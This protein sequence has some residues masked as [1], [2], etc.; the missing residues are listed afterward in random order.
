MDLETQPQQRYFAIYTLIC[1]WKQ[2]FLLLNWYKIVTYIIILTFFLENCQFNQKLTL[3]WRHMSLYCKTTLSLTIWPNLRQ[4][5]K[6]LNFQTFQWIGENLEMQSRLFKNP[7]F[8][9]LLW[10]GKNLEIYTAPDQHFKIQMLNL[11]M[12]WEN[13]CP[14]LTFTVENK[15][16]NSHK[17]G[18][19][20]FKLNI[21]KWLRYLIP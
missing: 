19:S 6:N 3:L 18:W 14:N 11:W 12:S 10:I 4:G 15:M 16:G 1:V 8:P 9:S 13:L 5:D 20:H 17:R 21:Y 2:Y 7:N